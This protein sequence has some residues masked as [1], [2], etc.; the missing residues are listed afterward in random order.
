[1]MTSSTRPRTPMGDVESRMG[2]QPLEELHAERAVLVK[3]VAEL[4]ARYGPGG[5]WDALRKIELSKI[6]AVIMAEAAKNKIKVRVEDMDALA[7][8]DS[9]Y[10]EVVT[11]A[12]RQR[13]EW[14][15][16][17]DQIQGIDETIM[18]GQAVSRFITAEAHLDR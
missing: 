2:V 3:R 13:G 10:I 9:R 11:T 8:A 7:H 14:T 1:M 6:K 17:E 18:R 5:T 15:V 12:T 16:L 4:R